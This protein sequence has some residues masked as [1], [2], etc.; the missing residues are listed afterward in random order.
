[1]MKA[2]RAYIGGGAVGGRG[3]L[4]RRPERL[5]LPRGAQ[6]AVEGSLEVVDVAELFAG[7]PSSLGLGEC[8]VYSLSRRAILKPAMMQLAVGDVVSTARTMSYSGT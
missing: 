7:R 6:H 8:W 2:A 1:M 4:A 5:E 3:E